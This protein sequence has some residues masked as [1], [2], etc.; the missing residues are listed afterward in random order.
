MEYVA[1]ILSNIR[2]Q[3]AASQGGIGSQDLSLDYLP[4]IRPL[5]NPPSVVVWPRRS[6]ND[7]VD[8]HAWSEIAP[9]LER[10]SLA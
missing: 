10:L 3:Y 5:L 1:S 7:V 8:V 9:R 4:N 6:V 2:G